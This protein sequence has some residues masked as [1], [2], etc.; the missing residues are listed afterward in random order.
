MT[1]S[2]D[3]RKADGSGQAICDEWDPA[4][5]AVTV[6]DD[7]GDGHSRH[8]VHGIE[9]ARVK[10][11]MSAVE[12]TVGVRSVT[13]ILKGLFSSCDAFE[14]EVER[15]AIRESLS[16]KKRSLLRVGIPSYQADDVDRG[17]NRRN[18]CSGVLAAE[19]SVEA[20]ETGSRAKVWGGV[21]IRSDECRTDTDDR[22]AGKPVF[23]FGNLSRK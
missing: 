16:R 11:I 17:R 12:E 2:R 6:G 22:Q 20:T 15:K 1:V 21:R 19:G 18:K 4:T 23:A 9:T 5:A 3:P 7:R 14:C 8:G 10:W 13:H